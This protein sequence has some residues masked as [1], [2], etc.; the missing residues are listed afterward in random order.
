[1]TLLLLSLMQQEIED[2]PIIII[3]N[4]TRDPIIIIFNATRDRD[5]PIIIILI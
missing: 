1:M 2:D 4:A 5:D 3:F